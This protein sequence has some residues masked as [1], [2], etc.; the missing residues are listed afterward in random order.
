VCRGF[1]TCVTCVRLA[2]VANCGGR[3]RVYSKEEKEQ[4]HERERER[5]R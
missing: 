2:S 5:E 4:E 3:W 1:V